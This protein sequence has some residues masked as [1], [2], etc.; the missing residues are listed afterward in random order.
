MEFLKVLKRL[1][2][3]KI[4][5]SSAEMEEGSLKLNTVG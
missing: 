3:Q 1:K 4:T 2:L 5:V